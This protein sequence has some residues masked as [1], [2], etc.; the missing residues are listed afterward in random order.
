MSNLDLELVSIVKCLNYVLFCFSF[1]RTMIAKS[2]FVVAS[3][4]KKATEEG[5]AKRQRSL[6]EAEDLFRREKQSATGFGSAG[7][8]PPSISSSYSSS[9]YSYGSKSVAPVTSISS[10]SSGYSYGTGYL[11]P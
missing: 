2:L 5:D 8:K 7:S 4:I 3:A 9:N 6:K 11:K 1:Y 10:S